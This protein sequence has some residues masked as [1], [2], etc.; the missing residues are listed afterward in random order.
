MLV[1]LP[2]FTHAQKTPSKKQQEKNITNNK[3]KRDRE[4]AQAYEELRKRHLNNQSKEAR[5]RMKKNS[6]RAKRVNNNK[7]PKKKGFSL[8]RLFKR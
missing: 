6:K 1:S 5:K 3:A 7:G 8:R 2:S 4:E